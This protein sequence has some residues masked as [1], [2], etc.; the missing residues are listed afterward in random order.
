MTTQG[1][2]FT[3]A[4]LAEER[5]NGAAL[6][7]RD[8]SYSAEQVAIIKSTIAKGLTD[9]E[10]ALFIEVCK[11]SGLDPFRRQ[12]YAIKRRDNKRGVDVVSH[13]TG[14]DGFRAIA[15][16]SG[17][18][19]GQVGPFWCGTDGAW[20]DVW[21]T[22][23]NPAAA[24]VGVYRKGCRD[25][26]WAVARFEAYRQDTHFWRN[27]GDNQIAKCAESLALRKAFPEDLSGLYTDTEMD[28]AGKAWTPPIDAQFAEVDE[29]DEYRRLFDAIDSSSTVAQLQAS[30]KGVNAALKAKTITPLHAEELTRLKD[31]RKAAL[32]RAPDTVAAPPPDVGGS[33]DADSPENP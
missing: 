27:M 15:S 29:T 16:R 7:H 33:D 4:E 23:Q 9:G 5:R 18:Y 24:K 3:T 6:V 21:L 28:Q 31:E 25:P 26:I 32:T 30:F 17:A 1:T 11:R 8:T 19:E 12:I 14:I 22:A 20:K 2:G 10:L 13:Q